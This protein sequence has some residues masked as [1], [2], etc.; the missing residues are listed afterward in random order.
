MTSAHDKICER[1]L[2][3]LRKGIKN[4][5]DLQR[6]ARLG[7]SRTIKAHIEHLVKE[8]LIRDRRKPQ[9]A[10]YTHEVSLTKKGRRIANEIRK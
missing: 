3:I 6:E 8:G 7:S 5:A 1:F 9:G 4:Y 10:N 2:K